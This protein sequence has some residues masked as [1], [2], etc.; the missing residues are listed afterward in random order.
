MSIWT[1]IFIYFLV[2]IKNIVDKDINDIVILCN[3][4]YIFQGLTVLFAVLHSMLKILKPYF[5]MEKVVLW[6]IERISFTV[7]FAFSVIFI[8]MILQE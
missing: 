4:F 2:D 1:I 5:N 8:V 7:M 6:C 3:A